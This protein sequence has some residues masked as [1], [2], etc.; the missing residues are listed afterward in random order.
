MTERL[1]DANRRQVLAG[2]GVLAVPFM[3]LGARAF[4]QARAR[5]VIVGGGFG[6]ATAARSLRRLLPNADITLVESNAVYT[7]CPFSNLVIGGTRDIND[8][9][10]TYAPLAQSGITVLHDRAIAIDAGRKE[11]KLG[12][13][14]LITY[15]R[16]ILSP[17]IDFRW[18]AID[19]YDQAAADRAPHAWK[20]GSQTILLRNQLAA[21]DDGGLVVMSV[22]APPFRCPPGP[23]ERASLIANY[24]KSFKPRSKLLI[25]DH[26]DSFSKMPLFKEA[27]AENYPDHLEWRGASDD[28]RVSR[29]DAASLTLSTDF[30]DIRADVAN[31]IPPQKAGEIARRAGVVDATGWCPINATSF[32]S[33]LQNGIHVIGDAT[34]AAPLPKSAFSANLQAKICAIAVARLVSDMEPEPTILANTCYSFVTPDQAVSISGVYS[35]DLGQFRNIEGAGG[36]SPVGATSNVR[37]AEAEQAEA[38]FAAT[39]GEAF[40]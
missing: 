22:P 38:W 26:Q 24:L 18:G 20:A 21:M 37:T 13:G 19:G 2:L 39:T 31:I 10:F 3:D 4:A 14:A 6:G 9:T 35:N 5:I 25:L 36:L 23:Y 8:Q 12:G 27:W 11:V 32:E 1:S 34:I 28:G 30:D 15:D 40:G 16:L 33:T 29:F 7:A 17:G